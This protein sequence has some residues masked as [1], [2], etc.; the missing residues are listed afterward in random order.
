MKLTK[1]L[2]TALYVNN[3]EKAEE[4]YVGILRLEVVKRSSSIPAR[5][6]FLRCGDTML[7]LFDPEQTKID[8]GVV[9]IHGT[10]GQGHMAFGISES[11][12]ESWVKY[13]IE[14]DVK[15]EKSVKWDKGTRS[16]YFRDPSGNS[17]EFIS[18][19]HWF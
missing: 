11:D 6:L 12:F 1:I 8:T 13:L 16:I 3:I 5:D 17:L 18:E 10:I 2:E 9:P 19:N 15:I 4:F 14:K 7:L